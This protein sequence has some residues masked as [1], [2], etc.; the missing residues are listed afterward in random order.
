MNEIAVGGARVRYRVE[1]CGPPLV[2]I[3]GTGPGSVTWDTV[4][5]R[6]TGHNTVIL[7]DLSGSESCEDDGGALT[8]QMLAEQVAA[9]I[10]DSGAA[11]V[12]VVGF[13]LGAPVAAALAAT[14]AKLVRRLVT[15]AGWSHSGDEYIRNAM[16]VWRSL[17]GDQEAFG[18]YAMLSAF[19]RD[20]L[21]SIGRAAVEEI[22]TYMRPT[23]NLLRQISANLRVDIQDL[24]PEIQA[25]T[26][27]IGC[28][29]DALIPVGN[30]RELVAA[31]PGGVY[32]ELDSG[33][34]VLAERPEEFTRLVGDFIH[35][36]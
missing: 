4:L 22:A 5:D 1:G 35:R 26:L 7:P 23:P 13:S 20:H 11:P 34:V 19:S 32:A 17:V 10:A 9:V 3:H 27:V 33:H 24:L 16:T 28:A 12:D 14:R 8:V 18:R 6:F 15:V 31:I 21:N 25:P 2:M 29:R 36:P 30:S